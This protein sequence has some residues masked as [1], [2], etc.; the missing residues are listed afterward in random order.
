MHATLDY[1]IRICFSLSWMEF[2]FYIKPALTN[3]YDNIIIIIW[4]TSA[5]STSVTLTSL[6]LTSSV[7]TS[8]VLTSDNL[9]TFF[10]GSVGSC[11]LVLASSSFWTWSALI[12]STMVFLLRTTFLAGVVFSTAAN[13]LFSDF[14]GESGFAASPSLSISSSCV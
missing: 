5:V 12:S 3:N 1:S 8:L 10:S 14:T 7:F 2:F 9:I 13:F 6:V 4:I 11:A